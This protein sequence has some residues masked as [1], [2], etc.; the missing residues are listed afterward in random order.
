VL[1]V[2]LF[3]LFWVVL[4]LGLFYVAI[5]GG[6]GGVRAALQRQ[7]RRGRRAMSVTFWI[8]FVGFGVAIPLAILTG[9][10][11]KASSQIGGIKLNAAEKQ[12]RLLF[13]EHCG[14]CHT[15][16]AA[17]AS[18]KVGPNL[19]QLRPPA[20]LVYNT[21]LNGCVQ[22]PPPGSPQACL[23]YGTMPAGVL[24]PQDAEKVAAFVGK[25]AGRE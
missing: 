11:A 15:L 19:D 20:S 16:A 13:G 25:V 9:N 24:E 7:T 4:G 12:G 3:I 18:G 21:I 2:I 6:V 10:H 17:N 22:N 8:V 23:G 1:G 14:V 5:R